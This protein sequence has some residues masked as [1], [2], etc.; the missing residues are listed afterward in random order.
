MGYRD[1]AT[2]ALNQGAAKAVSEQQLKL[3][4]GQDLVGRFLERELIKSK[5]SRMPD[6]YRYRFEL[7]EGPATVIFSNSFDKMDGARL[8][9]GKIYFIKYEGK[10]N[11][12]GGRAF[13]RYTVFLIP[14]DESELDDSI[15]PDEV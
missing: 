15:E 6:F 3:E 5:K 13:K 10:Q 2:A 9:P 7:D 14:E 12:S 8:K 1:K 11:I 4:E